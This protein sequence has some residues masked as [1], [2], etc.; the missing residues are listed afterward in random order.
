MIQQ[1]ALRIVVSIE[2]N[3][4]MCPKPEKKQLLLYLIYNQ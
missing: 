4:G 3:M 2:S 1:Y